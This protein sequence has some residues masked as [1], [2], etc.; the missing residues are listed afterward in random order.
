MESL[1]WLGHRNDWPEMEMLLLAAFIKL[2]CIDGHGIPQYEVLAIA[3]IPRRST[4]S[5]TVMTNT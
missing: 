3:S 1:V 5:Q 4:K 2:E